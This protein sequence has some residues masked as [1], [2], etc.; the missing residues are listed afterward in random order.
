LPSISAVET[1]PDR[2]VTYFEAP[3]PQELW[4]ELKQGC[5]D[6]IRG[7]DVM[8]VPHNSNLSN[9]GTFHVEYPGVEDEAGQRELASL[10]AK[11][12]PVVEVFQHKG[13][14]ECMNGLWGVGGEADPLCGFEK[15]REAGPQDCRDRPGILGDER[16]GCVSRLDYVRNVLIE[17][18]KE[19]RRIGV[20][21]YRLG[22]IADTDTH[23]SIPG[24][25]LEDRY[26]GHS[27][28]LDDT[29]QERLAIKDN[30]VHSPGGLTAVWAEENT[31]NAIFTALKKREVYATSGPRIEVRF[32]GGWGYPDT[33]CDHPDFARVGYQRGVPMGEV[34]PP[35]PTEA[36][37]PGFAVAARREPD[38]L[39]GGGTPLQRIEIIKGWLDGQGELM[40]RV[41]EVAGN[42][43]NGASVD[44]DTC[45]GVGQGFEALCTVWRDPDFDP[46]EPAYCYARVVEN[47][48]CRW[49]A[50]ECNRLR[51]A[52]QELPEA[53][54]EP[55]LARS[56]QE[57]AWTSPIWYRPDAL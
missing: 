46:A 31:R 45:E 28:N 22:I 51:E 48:T 55:D 42:P 19:E 11:V 20:N 29:P 38:P 57:R 21:P 37:T 3:T 41:F 14:S 32:F 35:K 26:V 13:D 5:L 43:D 34:L 33:L 54:N 8:A 52:G 15:I 16:L 47:P 17:G 23:D 50:Y 10:R 56:V 24:Q 4:R 44:P 6:G 39:V 1:V 30:L 36:T 25:V 2:P 18:L 40:T 12:E 53:C 49:S 9:G 7:C 27:A